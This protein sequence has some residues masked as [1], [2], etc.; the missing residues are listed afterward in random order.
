MNMKIGKFE[1]LK[2]NFRALKKLA[3]MSSNNRYDHNFS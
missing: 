2:M 3:V 1:D